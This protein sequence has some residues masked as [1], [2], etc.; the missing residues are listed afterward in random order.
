M[1]CNIDTLCPTG[2]WYSIKDVHQAIR[3]A[4]PIT[5]RRAHPGVVVDCS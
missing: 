2:A 1:V 5:I 3:Q 4:S